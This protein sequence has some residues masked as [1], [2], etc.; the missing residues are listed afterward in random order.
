MLLFFCHLLELSLLFFFCFFLYRC[1]T[2]FAYVFRVF[3]LITLFFVFV[4]YR[5]TKYIFFWKQQTNKIS[6]C[7]PSKF[8]IA[9]YIWV[10]TCIDRACDGVCRFSE[11]CTIF[12]VLR[13]RYQVCTTFCS[14]MCISLGFFCFFSRFCLTRN[15]SFF[16][17]LCSFFRFCITWST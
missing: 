5:Y 13:I 9:S 12:Y 10:D 14:I 4:T 8:N 17:S 3:C 2:Y 1:S 15:I 11:W 6:I 16:L 7:F